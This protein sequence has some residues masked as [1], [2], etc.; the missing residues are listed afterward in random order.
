MPNLDIIRT[1]TVEKSFRN[2]SILG[3]YDIQGREIV[4]RFSVDITLPDDWS[5]GLIVGPSGSGKT[6]IVNELFADAISIPKYSGRSVVDEMPPGVSMEQIERTFGAVGFSSPPS[7]VK[8]YH[9]LSN[10]EKMRVDLAWCLLNN[11]KT[12]VFDEFTSVVDR[13]IAKIA[14]MC[15]QKAVRAQNK[16]FVA[17][18]CHYDIIDWL[19]PDWVLDTKRMTL[20][21]PKKKGQRSTLESEKAQA[22]SGRYLLDIII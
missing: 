16:Q 20:T 1:S 4:E 21:T 5:V 11:E 13:Q 3:K 19:M 12:V 7:W 14:S 10:G 2:D 9:V 6:T 18:S 22:Q 8:P 17:V 15:V